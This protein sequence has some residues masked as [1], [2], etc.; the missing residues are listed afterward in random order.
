M[1]C[2]ASDIEEPPNFETIILFKE[3]YFLP[4]EFCRL[5][6][7]FTVQENFA[8]DSNGIREN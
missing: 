8:G 5:K 1:M 7:Y 6:Y 2:E 3:N 4:V